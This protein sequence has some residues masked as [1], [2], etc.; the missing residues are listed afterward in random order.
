MVEE[1][2]ISLIEN[3]G[4]IGIFIVSAI[5]SATVI[6]PLP[7][8]LAIPIAAT[9]LNPF[10]I[11]IFGGLGAT[12]GEMVGYG[13]GIGSRKLSLKAKKDLDIW[14]T[15]LSE[16]F[17]KYNGFLIII[18][19]SATPLPFDVIGLFAGIIKYDVKK[20]FLA[21]LIGRTMLY[22]I[23]AYASVLGIDAITNLI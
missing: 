3:F 18:I 16:L 23:L 9:S 13:I 17:K 10:L 20:F 4:Y 8:F 12:V 11:G 6:L 22:M 2:A 14:F 19:F 7:G 5:S 15:R 1:I 21:T